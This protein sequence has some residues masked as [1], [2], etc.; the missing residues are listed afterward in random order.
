L[1]K[2]GL[3]ALRH[4]GKFQGFTGFS[5]VAGLYS[6]SKS[7]RHLRSLFYLRGDFM[8]WKVNYEKDGKKDCLYFGGGTTEE[9]RKERLALMEIYGFKVLSCYPVKNKEGD[10]IG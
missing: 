3:V 6:V 7:S 9:Q 4:L 10:S 1:S 2:N 8:F 5:K